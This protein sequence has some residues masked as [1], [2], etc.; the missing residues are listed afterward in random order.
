MAGPFPALKAYQGMPV[1]KR[2]LAFSPGTGLT[3]L[4]GEVALTLAG[5]AP[6]DGRR[7]FAVSF[8]LTQVHQ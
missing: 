7:P 8:I 6:S 2:I 4:P 1:V 3:A 5:W